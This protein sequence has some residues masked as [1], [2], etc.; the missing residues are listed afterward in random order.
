MKKYKTKMI[1]ALSHNCIFSLFHFYL[2]TKNNNEVISFVCC[3]ILHKNTFLY[4]K[5]LCELHR[6]LSFFFFLNTYLNIHNLK[7]KLG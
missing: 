7:M 3:S 5:D 4:L 6:L 2:L 1:Y